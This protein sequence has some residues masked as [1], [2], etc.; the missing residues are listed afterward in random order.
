MLAVL[1]AAPLVLAPTVSAFLV[2]RALLA[3]VPVAL[4]VSLLVSLLVPRLMPRLKARLRALLVPAWGMVALGAP[5]VVMAT[6]LVV[7]RADRVVVTG[8]LAVSASSGPVPA[9]RLAV[10]R[11]RSLQR[12]RRRTEVGRTAGFRCE[13]GLARRARIPGRASVAD[14]RSVPVGLGLERCRCGTRVGGL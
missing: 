1:V 12:G 8:V 7:M 11:C 2:A 10:V 4:L 6:Q 3:P 9:G 14:R 13:P 5:G